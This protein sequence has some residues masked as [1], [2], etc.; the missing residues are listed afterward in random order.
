MKALLLRYAPYFRYTL[1]LSLLVFRVFFPSN[2]I[3]CYSVTKIKRPLC[4]PQSWNCVSCRYVSLSWRPLTF[5]SLVLNVAH[6]K[7]RWD[8]FC[9]ECHIVLFPIWLC[10]LYYPLH[11]S[12]NSLAAWWAYRVWAWLISIE[13]HCPC[14]SVITTVKFSAKLAHDKVSEHILKPFLYFWSEWHLF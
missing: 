12:I 8:H 4:L 1:I 9:V 6:K 7:D 13:L 5:L 11:Y 2:F 3:W 14:T 10:A